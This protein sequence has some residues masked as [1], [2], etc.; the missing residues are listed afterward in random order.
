[1]LKTKLYLD[2]ENR[3]SCANGKTWLRFGI[4]F[5]N[6]ALFEVSDACVQGLEIEYGN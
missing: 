2:I 1:M 3:I 5:L 6:Q 4:F